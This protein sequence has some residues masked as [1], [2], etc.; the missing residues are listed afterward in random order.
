MLFVWIDRHSFLLLVFCVAL[1]A[2]V[3]SPRT[4][5]CGRTAV[6]SVRL[7]GHGVGGVD[8]VLRRRRVVAG[9]V[10]G[11]SNRHELVTEIVTGHAL[12]SRRMG[13][14]AGEAVHVAAG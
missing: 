8:L 9:R 10:S 1:V 14:V 6:V 7:L 5:Q 13:A 11:V 12:E 3:T 4:E 2:I